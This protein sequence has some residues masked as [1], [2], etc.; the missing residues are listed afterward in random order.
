M[1]HLI[2]RGL[3]SLYAT[4]SADAR[5]TVVIPVEDESEGP[6]CAASACPKLKQRPD[7]SIIIVNS[8]SRSNFHSLPTFPCLGGR[9][10]AQ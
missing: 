7:P 8:L 6:D 10:T 9:R 3:L 5:H 2:S 4:V 1:M